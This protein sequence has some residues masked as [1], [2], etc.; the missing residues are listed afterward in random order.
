MD[1]NFNKTR[2]RAVDG[3]SADLIMCLVITEW[4][5]LIRNS[6]QILDQPFDNCI[7]LPVEEINREMS[8]GSV[9]ECLAIYG[10]EMQEIYKT[11]I[12]MRNYG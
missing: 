5:Q 8:K 11:M 7:H 3:V 12:K 1:I 10:C 6:K 9:A 2:Y 4:K